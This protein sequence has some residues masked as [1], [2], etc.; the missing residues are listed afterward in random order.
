MARDT[1]EGERMED[2]EALQELE[3][4]T[5]K[6]KLNVERLRKQAAKREASRVKKPLESNKRIRPE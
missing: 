6:V 3:I 1:L 5:E 2:A 4:D